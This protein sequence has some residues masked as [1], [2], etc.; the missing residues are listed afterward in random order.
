VMPCGVVDGY[1][2]LEEDTASILRAE[3]KMEAVCSSE[4][5][6]PTYSFTHC[7]NP[8]N[9]C[10]LCGNVVSLKVTKFCETSHNHYVIMDFPISC[11]FYILSG[12]TAC[13][14]L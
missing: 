3:L 7:C 10:H 11:N 4:M 6:L 2:F 9:H 14:Q 8:Y 1:Q 13:A 5:F 12:V